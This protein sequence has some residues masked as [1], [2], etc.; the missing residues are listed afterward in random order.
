MTLNYQMFLLPTRCEVGHWRVILQLNLNISLA[1]SDDRNV[2]GVKKKKDDAL[3]YTRA[4]ILHCLIC[5]QEF[6]LLAISDENQQ[7]YFVLVSPYFLTES[8]LRSLAIFSP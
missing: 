1:W 8:R 2:S 6:T 7:C 4:A 3:R 5:M